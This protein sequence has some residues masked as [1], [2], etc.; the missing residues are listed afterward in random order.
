MANNLVTVCILTTKFPME[1]L[2]SLGNQTY[3]N[4]E[5]SLA[6][7]DG[8]VKALNL[9][10]VRANGDIFVRLDDDVEMPPNWLEELVKPF[11]DPQVAGVTGPTF[12]P[13]EL[14]QNRDSIRWAENPN[15]FLRW[16]YDNGEFNPA[17]IR[18]C[19]CVS[20]DSNYEE[21]FIDRNGFFGEY[22]PDHLEGT[23]WA[24]R[25]ALVRKVLGFDPKFDGVSEWIDDDV[26]FKVKKLGFKL[27]YNPKAYLYHLLGGGEHFNN[28]FDGFGRLKNW[29]R[30]HIRHSKFHPKMVIYFTIW[31]LYFLRKSW[32]SRKK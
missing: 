3:R 6:R 1:V 17:G 7:E 12:V 9:A 20:Y 16:L 14:R 15:W 28:R 10:L 29:L 25:T 24:M 4:F 19:G 31:S 2:K 8:I 32:Q 30:F 5:I 26:V 27:A 21:R 22:E 11:S 13:K 18:K 23:N